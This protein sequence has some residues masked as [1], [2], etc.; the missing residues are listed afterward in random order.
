[1]NEREGTA[2][3]WAIVVGIVLVAVGLLGFVSNPLV[4]DSSTALLH[5]DRMHDIVHIATGALALFIGLG[6]SGRDQAV[7]LIGFGV[8]YAVVFAAMMVSPDLFGLMSM[9]A[10][11]PLHVIHAALALG[12][13]VIGYLALRHVEI[14]RAHV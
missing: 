4:G 2:R 13:L 8:L 12:S 7:G 5:T 11:A 3:V 10:N 6:L 14:G 1:M 9:P